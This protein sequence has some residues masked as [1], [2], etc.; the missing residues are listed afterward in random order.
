MKAKSFQ[1]YLETRLTKQEIADIERQ[2]QLE[3]EILKY[4]QRLRRKRK[5]VGPLSQDIC[6]I[7]LLD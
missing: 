1:A 6:T 3:V 7:K 4:R 5:L 2:A